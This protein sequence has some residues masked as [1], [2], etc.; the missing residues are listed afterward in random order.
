MNKM[1]FRQ[2]VVVL[3]CTIAA[4]SFFSCDKEDKL[5]IPEVK[6]SFSTNADYLTFIK[7]GDVLECTLKLNAE[8]SSEGVHID[9]V[10]YYWD[11]QTQMT[12]LD[13]DHKFSMKITN[14]ALGE[15]TLRAEVHCSGD[16]YMDYN[17]KLSHTFIVVEEYPVINFLAEFPDT[18]ANGDVFTK[19]VMVKVGGSIGI[20]GMGSNTLGSHKVSATVAFEKPAMTTMSP[21]E[22]LS[23]ETLLTP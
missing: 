16:G 12:A 22:A 13:S 2:I 15:H 5:T 1:S 17:V 23:N 20:A 14:Q 8:E 3:T 4:F 9:K 11:E 6:I 19:K 7:N 10:E 18:I 21:A